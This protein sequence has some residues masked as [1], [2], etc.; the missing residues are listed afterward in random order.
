M[1]EYDRNNLSF[2][3]NSTPET[4]A[5]WYATATPDDLVYTQ[6]LLKAWGQELTNLAFEAA[7]E[8]AE[9]ALDCLENKFTDANIVLK[10]FTKSF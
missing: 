5:S 1:T 7:W 4:I 6:E 10:K 9:F 3:I 8:E 2:L